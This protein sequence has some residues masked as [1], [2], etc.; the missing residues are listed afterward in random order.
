MDVRDIANAIRLCAITN[1]SSGIYNLGTKNTL[2]NRELA[3]KCIKVSNS[4]SLITYDGKDAND[5][6]EWAI[7]TSKIDSLIGEWRRFS[8]DDTLLDMY[9]FMKVN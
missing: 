4:R 1:I 7:N 6:I 9:R 8:I 5:E 3:Y 2:S